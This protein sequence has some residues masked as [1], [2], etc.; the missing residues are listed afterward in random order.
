MARL[1]LGAAIDG[2]IAE[3]MARDP[4][5]IVLGED[6]HTLR[7][8][9]FARFGPERVLAAPIS[10][11]AFLGAAIVDAAVGAG[12]GGEDGCVGAAR[13]RTD[14]RRQRRIR[15]GHKQLIEIRQKVDRRNGS[16]RDYIGRHFEHGSKEMPRGHG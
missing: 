13:I 3:A 1:E 5:V 4:R 14:R 10:E 16:V 8:P 15:R 2:A 11:A 7:A 12:G 6:V 9:L